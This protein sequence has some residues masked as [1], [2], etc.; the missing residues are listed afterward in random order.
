MPRIPLNDFVLKKLKSE[1][2]QTQFWDAS[3]PSFGCRCSPGGTKTFNVMLGK[4]RRLI[5]IGNYPAMNLAEARQIAHRLMAEVTPT[6][7]SFAAARDLF[8]KKHLATLK[9]TTAHE[10]TNLMRRFPF[11]KPLQAI[12]QHDIA[13]VLDRMPRGSA[14]SCYNVFRT[15]LNWCVANDHLAA[16]PLKR[17]S[18]YKST[19]RERLLSDAE[20]I[21]I[22]RASYRLHLFGSIIRCLILSGQRLNQFASFSLAWVDKATI[23]F[24]AFIMKSNQQ[25]IIPL[26]AELEM[27]LPMLIKPFTTLSTA[28]VHLRRAL[29]QDPPIPHF[30]LHDFRRY[31]S[32]TM[33]KLGVPIDIT[34]ALLAHTAGS[35]SPIQRIYDRYDRLEPMRKALERYE[36]H[37]RSLGL[38]DATLPPDAAGDP[39]RAA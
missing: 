5:K 38:I 39:E 7:I 17:K 29:P 3:L 33:A 22:W 10:Q 6:S 32:S 19:P 14:R 30:T 2:R 8:V 15:F 27:H 23:V 35:R 16:S 4:Q 1:G 28:T 37:L 31:F 11:N 24:P 26:S 34:E 20:I 25:H 18:P 36:D 13:A 12:T 9:S 21:L